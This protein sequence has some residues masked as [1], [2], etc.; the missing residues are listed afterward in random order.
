MR[1][2]RQFWRDL[3]RGYSDRDVRDARYKIDGLPVLRGNPP[4]VTLYL[5]TGQWRAYCG[6]RMHFAD[7][8]KDPK[9]AATCHLSAVR[10]RVAG[11]LVLMAEALP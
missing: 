5:T 9:A 6:E 8:M 11:R 2:F 10:I 3:R 1:T 7:G 4:F